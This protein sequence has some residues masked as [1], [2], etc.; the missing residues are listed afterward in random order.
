[1]SHR[2]AI[3][4]EAPS[5]MIALLAR[6]TPCRKLIVLAS[7]AVVPPGKRRRSPALPGRTTAI[8]IA[9]AFADAGIPHRPVTGNVRVAPAFSPGPPEG[10]GA[11]RVSATRQGGTVKKP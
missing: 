8:L 3:S 2:T 10:P 9:T 1:M 6:T 5:G 11:P 4:P 7:G